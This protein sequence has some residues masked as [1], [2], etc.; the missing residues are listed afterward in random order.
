[1]KIY[2][3]DDE[4]IA[5]RGTI[6]IIN[7]VVPDA[8]ITGF[9]RA[10]KA[11]EHVTQTGEKPDVVFSDI[12]MPGIRG[13]DFAVSFKTLCPESK[14]IFVT[15]YSH[16]ALEAFRL[17]V[18]GYIMKPITAE[19]VKEELDYALKDSAVGN[20][21]QKAGQK[22]EDNTE[23]SQNTAVEEKAEEEKLLAQCF[24]Y[25]EVFFN[26]EVIRRKD[27]E[28]NSSNDFLIAGRYLNDSPIH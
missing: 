16:Y 6:K 10:A 8:E 22:P 5:L 27:I 15:A 11:I 24:G 25:F 2:V 19:R 28:A 7:E 18:H 1:M 17:H 13:L 12:E 26:S 20:D 21:R 4:P 23:R 9:S 14:I 3:L